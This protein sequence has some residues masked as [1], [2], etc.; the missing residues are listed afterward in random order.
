MP[1]N[2]MAV[3][4]AQARTELVGA[5]DGGLTST[6]P[7]ADPARAAELVQH[8]L[9]GSNRVALQAAAEYCIYHYHKLPSI[10]VS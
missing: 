6:G 1:R 5:P 9:V 8:V 2:V 4:E 3:L 7:L 10:A